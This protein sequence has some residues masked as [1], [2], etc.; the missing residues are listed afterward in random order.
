MINLTQHLATPEQIQ[1][2]V[3]DLGSDFRK[4]LIELLTFEDISET[5]VSQMRERA[6]KIADL[7]P[8]FEASALIGGALYFMPYLIKALKE[9]GVVP[10]YSF[11]KRDTIEKIVNG[12]VIKTAIFKHVG[13]VSAYN[14]G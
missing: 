10:Y 14:G 11:T 4:A 7:V 6:I 2:G 5:D 8:E 3:I 1:E 9:N 12:T 13:F